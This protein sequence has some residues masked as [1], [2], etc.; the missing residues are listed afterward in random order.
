M[1]PAPNTAGV[2]VVIRIRNEGRF[3]R[4]VLAAL[5]RQEC[6]P[7]E[8]IVV[9]NAS[10]DDTR[11][12]AAAAGARILPLSTAGFSYGKALNTGIREARGEIVCILSAHALPI[13]SGFLRTA[14]APFCD[15]SV[16]AVRCLSVTNRRELESWMLATDLEAPADLERVIAEAPVNCAAMIRRSVWEQLPYDE[17]MGSVEDKFWA[18]AVLQRGYRIAKS[19]AP[20]LYLRDTS[21]IDQVRRMNRDRLAYFRV[22]GQQFGIPPVR[23]GRLL[24]TLLYRIPRRAL[25][26]AFYETA[27]YA[28][29]KSIPLQALRKERAGSFQ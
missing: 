4:P 15:P 16:A 29:V 22:T 18:L 3:L 2:S 8:I 25:R 11:E 10:T 17:T 1:T 9:D 28:Y 13:G 6:P 24:A 26:T 21:V 23:M 12:V 7:I 19:E 14:A 5:A 20:Y 27:L